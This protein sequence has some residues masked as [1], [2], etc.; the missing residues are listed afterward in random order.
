M[1]GSEDEPICRFPGP[2]RIAALI[3]Q[4][5][6]GESMEL[7]P[8]GRLV[9]HGIELEMN[10]YCRRAVS[11][12]VEWSKASG[13]TCSVFTLGPPTAEDC[14][15]EALAWGADRALH[16]C[17]E[18]FA[19]SDTLATARALAAALEVDGPF[20]L[21]LVGLNTLDGDTGQVGPEVAALLDLPFVAGARSMGIEDRVLTMTLQHDDGWQDVT[22]ELPA[23][24]SVAER[25]CEP[26]KV[27]PAERAAVS[28]ELIRRL[29]AVELGDGPWGQGAS[30]TRVGLVRAVG[31]ERAGKVLSGPVS[32]QVAE[33]LALLVQRGALDRAAPTE[34]P[35]P[36]GTFAVSEPGDGRPVGVLVEEGR[37]RLASELVGAA[38]SLA[39]VFGSRV[40]AVA[41]AGVDATTLA[42]WGAH[43][44]T[45]L[46]GSDV[47][48]DVADAL[49]RWA[50]EALPRIVLGPSTTFGREVLGRAAAGLGAGLVG[51]AI[52]V[53]VR[54]GIPV[55]AKPAF[56]GTMIADITWDSPVGMVSVRPGVLPLREPR[57][58]AVAV[59]HEQRM[60][61]RG[62]VRVLSHRR[63]DD[64]EVLARAGVVIG[65]G[66]AVAPAEYH[67][68]S[69]LAELL[70]AEL[71]A[72]RK[73]TD[74][75]WAPRAR[76][77]GI[78]GRSIAP[79]LYVALGT[80]GKFNHMVGVR[81]AGTVLAVNHDPD[82]LV[83]AH[84]DI[85]IVGDWHEVIAAL[86]V[87][88]R[89]QGGRVFPK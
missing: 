72:T 30:P 18:G 66:A 81:A 9:R 38:A 10:A 15:R 79:H 85:G 37:P 11:K 53:S 3:K 14:L 77:V 31:R 23:V 60:G 71:A 70:G 80:S 21:V 40:H 35:A 84:S 64:V 61:T 43:E 12:G 83:F 65:V 39:A 74:K 27:P 13:G 57:P 88:V 52:G 58:D 41:P 26:C 47:A 82:A 36:A 1:A 78:T 44:V 33:A 32:D 86:T 42:P 20:D 28:P 48:E 19:G 8:D 17:D 5:P 54:D 69:P 7:G 22:V 50:Q 76:Q 62:R 6:V 45:V 2:L 56:G 75:G 68:L 24:V 46:M 4:I 16:L 67:L 25:L 29:Q 89:E 63:D 49:V 34:H 51:D 55:A 87:A 73:V 59:L